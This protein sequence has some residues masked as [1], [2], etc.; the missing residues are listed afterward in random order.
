MLYNGI[1]I[2]LKKG[3]LKY[4]SRAM[5]SLFRGFRKVWERSYKNCDRF[6]SLILLCQ[7]IKKVILNIKSV[8]WHHFLRVLEKFERGLIRIAI[9]FF[10]QKI[11]LSFLGI[12]LPLL[13]FYSYFCIFTI[14]YNILL[15]FYPYKVA[16]A[17]NEC[18][19]FCFHMKGFNY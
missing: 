14:L 18:S 8:P 17:C 6:F 7:C 12:E 2:D 11:K 15:R 19:W 10:H 4:Q 3:N 13:I 5:A 16:S 1:S 9:V